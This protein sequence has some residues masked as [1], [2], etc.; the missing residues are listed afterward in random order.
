MKVITLAVLLTIMQASPPIPRQTP[1]N[2]AQAAAQVKGNG[3]SSQAESLPAPPPAKADG[4]G[5]AKTDSSEQHSADTPQTVGIS[6]L[7]PVTINPTK[8]DWADWAYWVFN[9]FLVAVGILQ[10][11]LLC[12]TFRAVRHQA[13]ESTRQR[14]TMRRQLTAMQG[15]LDQMENAGKQTDRL[16]DKT[17]IAASAAE[18]SANAIMDIERAWIMIEKVELI[19]NNPGGAEQHPRF[20][21]FWIKARNFGRS[22]AII[23]HLDTT[24]DFRE[25]RDASDSPLSDGPYQSTSPP[26]SSRVVPPRRY[27]IFRCDQKSVLD[28]NQMKAVFEG[29][30]WQFMFAHGV[31]RYRDAFGRQWYTRFNY[32]YDVS[33]FAEGH[34]AGFCFSG[35]PPGSNAWT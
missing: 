11:I 9:F 17:G 3:T 19:V 2:S 23:T 25:K 33:Y 26:E 6:K 15:Q 4:N 13:R 27:F 20:V 5:P 7:P 35:G 34:E 12:W 24:L 32:R 10:V 29:P 30:L 28:T 14:V 8:R 1:D 16:I 18:K 21:S 22:P 31:V